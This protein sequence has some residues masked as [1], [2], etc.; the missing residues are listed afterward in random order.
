MKTA[1]YDKNLLRSGGEYKSDLY[2]VKDIDQNAAAGLK[3]WDLFFALLSSLPMIYWM[4]LIDI[5]L[6]YVLKFTTEKR[7]LN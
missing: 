2:S 5:H 1:A 4:R 7:R 6:Y 3:D